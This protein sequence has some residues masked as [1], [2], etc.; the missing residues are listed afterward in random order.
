MGWGTSGTVF[1]E[2]LGRFCGG[3]LESTVGG[4]FLY[5]AMFTCFLL[6]FYYKIQKHI[7]TCILL[8][9]A[10]KPYEFPINPFLEISDL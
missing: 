10:I 9:F 2:V 8:F 4:F 7:F 1:E 6:I 5:F 3:I